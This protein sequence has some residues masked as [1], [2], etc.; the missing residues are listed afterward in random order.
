MLMSA[1]RAG[2][3]GLAPWGIWGIKTAQFDLSEACERS[4]WA[5]RWVAN[6][7]Y[8][9]ALC[10]NPMCPIRICRKWACLGSKRPHFYVLFDGETDRVGKFIFC[11]KKDHMTKKC[12]KAPLSPPKWANFFSRGTK[13]SPRKSD[14]KVVR[15]A[16]AHNFHDIWAFGGPDLVKNGQ[17]SALRP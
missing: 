5:R 16:G 13:I 8:I 12:P 17:K 3:L 4:V 11:K 9:E 15:N 10:V 1:F 14:R 6:P 7:E 2:L